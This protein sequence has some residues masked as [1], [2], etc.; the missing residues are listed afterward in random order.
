VTN[1]QSRPVTLITGSSRGIGRHLA[2]HYCGLGHRVIG[3]SRGKAEWSHQ[4]YEHF[5]A[6]VASEADVK[7]IFAD[8]RQRVGRLDHLSVARRPS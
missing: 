3:C 6:D 1:D 2:D 7:R 8:I 5:T 4:G